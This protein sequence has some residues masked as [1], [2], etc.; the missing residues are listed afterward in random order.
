MLRA[1]D[2]EAVQNCSGGDL[3]GLTPAGLER[4]GVEPVGNR[5]AE[6][7]D[8]YAG[9]DGVLPVGRFLILPGCNPVDVQHL[10]REVPAVAGLGTTNRHDQV[11]AIAGR[12]ARDVLAQIGESILPGYFAV[13]NLAPLRPAGSDGAAG[14]VV[15]AARRI[16]CQRNKARGFVAD[17]VGFD[18]VEILAGEVVVVFQRA[19][20]V[21]QGVE[22][23]AQLVV[24]L[25]LRDTP[26]SREAVQLG[27]SKGAFLGA[28]VRAHGGA[29]ASSLLARCKF[30]QDDATLLGDALFVVPGLGCHQN[31]TKTRPLLPLF[32]RTSR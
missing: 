12:A 29:L 27:G 24:D 4:A 10:Q 15:R 14:A 30:G 8:L 31:L 7:I 5:P 2:F 20:A 6:V 23:V 16:V 13:S 17:D 3:L 32:L 18:H 19:A 25:L 28:V 22:V 11:F 9:N 1:S 21:A 26:A